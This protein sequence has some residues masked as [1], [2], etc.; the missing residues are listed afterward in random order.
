VDP[1][2]SSPLFKPAEVPHNTPSPFP[3]GDRAGGRISQGQ[4]RARIAQVALASLANAPWR[5]RLDGTLADP[6]TPCPG[7]PDHSSAANERRR[8]ELI[9]HTA[10]CA[11]PKP[12]RVAC[13][14]PFTIGPVI[15]ERLLLR[16][17]LPQRE[18]FT[19][20]DFA[21]SR[22]S[23]EITR[24]DKHF[25]KESGNREKTSRCSSTRAEAF[26]VELVLH[27][28]GQRADQDLI[29][30]ATVRPS[31]GAAYSPRPSRSACVQADE[32]RARNWR[33]DAPTD[34]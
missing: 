2:P 25:T 6:T 21:R 8:W 7:T 16:L 5:G 34:V 29:F 26:K 10:P 22:R 4:P 14:H 11:W 13:R 20:E 12:C 18:P 19:P 23:R 15:R 24:A 9:R 3:T 28:S 1:V 32:S 17:L 30:G 31:A 33:G 27:H